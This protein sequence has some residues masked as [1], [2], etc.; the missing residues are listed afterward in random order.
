LELGVRAYFAISKK[1]SLQFSRLDKTLGWE[2]IPNHTSH[3][4]VEG[5]GEVKYSSGQYGFREFGE[6]HTSK[7]KIFVVGDSFTQGAYVSDELVYYDQFKKEGNFEVFAYGSGGFGTLQEYLILN[8]Y[9]DLIKPD[10]IL[11]QFCD[12]D[13]FNND[14]ELESLNYRHN[15]FMVRP[16]LIDGKI[17]YRYPL[18]YFKSLQKVAGSS[19]L[20]RLVNMLMIQSKKDKAPILKEIGPYHPLV[21]RSAKTTNSIMAQVKNRAG[22][23]P[24]VAFMVWTK[25]GLGLWANDIFK[26]I[27]TNNDIEYISDLPYYLIEKAQEGIA[28][29]TQEDEHWNVLGNKIAGE[30]ILDHISLIIEIINSD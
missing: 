2:S 22:E 18:R 15:N 26:Q 30:Y 12:N 11:W 7:K 25:S 16:Y 24:V 28:L 1:R 8:R 23:I 10:L 4:A 6:I 13:I 27:S 21:Y 19:H 20:F 3:H 17:E 9:I 29:D 5:Y 14:Y